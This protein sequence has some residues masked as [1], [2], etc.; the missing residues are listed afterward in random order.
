MT[1]GILNKKARDK[2]ITYSV[3]LGLCPQLRK[4]G[5]AVAIN[6]AVRALHG[7][8]AWDVLEEEGE[9]PENNVINKLELPCT[10]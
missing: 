9:R 3:I 8:M 2:L 1:A 5:L 10:V 6:A 4:I 7:L